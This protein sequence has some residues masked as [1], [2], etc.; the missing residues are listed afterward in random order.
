[1]NR[2]TPLLFVPV[3]VL[4]AAV[5]GFADD[6]KSKKKE[7]PTSGADHI[8][9]VP[10]DPKVPAKVDLPHKDFTQT[11]EDLIRIVDPDGDP[12]DPEFETKF[13]KKEK[14]K[15]SFEMVFV[16]GGT[17]QMGSPDGEAGRDPNEGPRHQV[18]VRP[19]WLAKF[20]TTWDVFDLWYKSGGLPRRDEADGKFQVETGDKTK[21]LPPDAITRPTN[22]YVDDT[23]YHDRAGKPALC[24]SH[25]AAMV[26]CHW[27]RLKTMKP[28]RLPTEAE[29]EYACRSGSDGPY[30]FD[31]KDKLADHAWF[32]DNSA[33]EKMPGGTTHE[34]GKKKPNKFGLYDLHGNVAEWTLDQF[35]PQ[36]YEARA[37]NPLKALTFNKPTEAKWG[38]VVRGGSWKDEA[39]DLRAARRIVSEK[40]WMQKDP[41]FPRSV[42]WLTEMDTVGLRVALPADEYPELVGLKPMVPKKGE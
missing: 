35:D 24:M 13:V 8:L 5:L 17:F 4:L 36:L 12:D 22:P 14:A 37:K 34:P 7:K 6:T 39:K 1:M 28:Y 33:T 21:R 2:R 31:P 42:W 32:K 9:P 19:F 41:Q 15:A 38:H 27:L 18:T 29:W 40:D 26:F 25:H 30:G 20:E 16:P 23:Y 11:V 3:V 10:A